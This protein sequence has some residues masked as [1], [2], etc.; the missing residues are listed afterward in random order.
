M[1]NLSV[2]EAYAFDYLAILEIKRDLNPET[3]N[4]W[5][6]CRNLLKD[7]LGSLLDSIILSVEYQELVSINKDVFE[8]V[9][10]ARYGQISAK[11]VDNKNMQRYYAKK[12]L[13]EKFFPTQKLTE[14][15]T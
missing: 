14:Y 10:L 15:K 4:A 3:Q 11:E 13:Q 2:D 6:L 1:I 9:D 5:V 8:A 12:T 7:Q